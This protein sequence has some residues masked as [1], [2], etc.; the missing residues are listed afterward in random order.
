MYHPTHVLELEYWGDD[1]YRYIISCWSHLYAYKAIHLKKI[2]CFPFPACMQTLLC[3][4][5]IDLKGS[6][7]SYNEP[8]AFVRLMNGHEDNETIFTFLHDMQ[9]QLD[10]H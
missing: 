2:Y 1:I 8:P 5:W 6:S 10:R 4:S 7:N 3:I 9:W